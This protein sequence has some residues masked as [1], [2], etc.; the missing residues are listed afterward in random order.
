MTGRSHGVLRVGD[1]IRLR[2]QAFTVATISGGSVK[3][4][5]AVDEPTIL[6]LSELL[7]N[8][9][10]EVL[11]GSR[12]ALSS[13]ELLSNVPE[14]IVK[15]SEVSAGRQSH[16]PHVSHMTWGFTRT[17]RLKSWSDCST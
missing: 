6:P 14:G 11:A 7:A 15:L 5:D 9:S 12:P 8:P 1:E 4:I 2:S 10:L 3:L 13:A 17:H 16:Q